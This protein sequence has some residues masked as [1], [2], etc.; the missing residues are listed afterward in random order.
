[1]C[2]SF[3]SRSTLCC[4]VEFFS[5]QKPFKVKKVYISCICLLLLCTPNS[6]IGAKQHGV[7]CGAFG[8]YL[9]PRHRCECNADEPCN[10]R[11]VCWCKRSQV[12]VKAIVITE[13]VNTSGSS[14][15][16][17]VGKIENS[18]RSAV[19]DAMENSCTLYEKQI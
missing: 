12:T 13:E 5:N 3:G 16:H 8:E 17:P 18:S 15:H 4:G 14:P 2:W 6:V 11:E 7:A 1:V 10:Q 19:V 9:W